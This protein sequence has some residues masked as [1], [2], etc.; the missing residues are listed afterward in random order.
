MK[1]KIILF[2]ID[3]TIFDT[4]GH[5]KELFLRISKLVGVSLQKVYNYLDIYFS[6]LKNEREYCSEDF[7]RTLT[8]NKDLQD[9]ILSYHYGILSQVLCAKYV[10]DEVHEM[11]NIL[12]NNFRLGIYSEGECKLQKSKIQG[13]NRYFDKDLIFIVD[14]KDNNETLEKLP[15][16]AI[17]IDD[18]EIICEFLTKNGFR[19]IWLNRKDDRKSERF[20][21]I[22]SLLELPSII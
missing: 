18:K 15:K 9:K 21:T 4:E 6:S 1:N 19:A 11:F 16:E 10:Y 13:L 2:D 22:H 7:A 3:R 8:V 12:S 20:K 5:R 17:I 14:A